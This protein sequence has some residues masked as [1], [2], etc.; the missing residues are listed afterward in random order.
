MKPVQLSSGL[1]AVCEHHQPW[2]RRF[3][4]NWKTR[5]KI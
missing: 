5:F 1:E 2:L 3:L 4:L